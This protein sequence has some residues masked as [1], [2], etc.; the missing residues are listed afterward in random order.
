MLVDL[1]SSSIPRKTSLPLWSL[2]TRPD[3]HG[4]LLPYREDG[5]GEEILVDFTKSFDSNLSLSFDVQMTVEVL[6][7]V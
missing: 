4:Q 2:L 3:Q 5:I 7:S 1:M 6:D